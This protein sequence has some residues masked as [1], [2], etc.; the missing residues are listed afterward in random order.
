V[1]L[2]AAIDAEVDQFRAFLDELDP[3]DFIETTATERAP[4]T[5]DDSN[6]LGDARPADDIADD[7]ADGVIENSTE[8][9]TDDSV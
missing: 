3:T 1:A 6:P 9:E 7:I 4:D 8:D 2:E 5:I